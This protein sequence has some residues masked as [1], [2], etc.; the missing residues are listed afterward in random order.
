MRNSFKEL[1]MVRKNIKNKLLEPEV[2]PPPHAALIALNR[3]CRDNGG[4][5]KCSH[6][7]QTSRPD[8]HDSGVVFSKCQVLL[9][10]LS[11][12]RAVQGKAGFVCWEMYVSLWHCVYQC[13]CVGVCVGGSIYCPCFGPLPLVSTCPGLR[14][15]SSS[16]WSSSSPPHPSLPH[17]PPEF[18]TSSPYYHLLFQGAPLHPSPDFSCTQILLLQSSFIATPF[19]PP[20]P[21]L[22]SYSFSDSPGKTCWLSQPRTHTMIPSLLSGQQRTQPHQFSILSKERKSQ[23]WRR[24]GRMTF[25][26]IWG[27]FIKHKGRPAFGGESWSTGHSKCKRSVQRAIN[28]HWWWAKTDSTVL[29]RFKHESLQFSFVPGSQT[30]AFLVLCDTILNIFDQRSNLNTSPWALGCFNLDQEMSEMKI[31]TA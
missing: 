23:G 24:A 6:W 19:L 22:S 15:L 13:V 29:G 21:R 18:F 28:I 5:K 27:M 14:L 4:K 10:P 16:F 2:N 20:F 31:V 9:W 26:L 3:L 7:K 8:R 25:F 17:S 30:F 12:F 1:L 11:S